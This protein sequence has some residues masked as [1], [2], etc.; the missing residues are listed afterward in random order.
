MPK[1]TRGNDWSAAEVEVTVSAYFD[2]LEAALRGERINKAARKRAVASLLNHRSPDAAE[3]KFRNISAI[4]A[5]EH[6]PYITGFTPLYNYQDLLRDVVLNH[7]WARHSTQAMLE[8]EVLTMPEP[9]SVDDILAQLTAAPVRQKEQ[10]RPARP[11]SVIRAPADYLLMESQ[12]RAL[13][14]AG[15]EFA[16]RFEQARLVAARQER[17]AARVEHVAVSRGDGLGFDVLSFDS[18]GRE[19][20]IE[21]KTTKSGEF[22]PFYVSRNELAVSRR[23]ASQYH[24]YR[25]FKYGASPRLF[26]VSGSLDRTCTLEPTTFIARA[27]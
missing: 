6:V 3:Y 10:R 20:L 9:P 5:E 4:L 15:E 23:E 11:T 8:D 22:M 14:R 12:N 24:L 7:L 2:M 19:R 13:G 1:R 17:L 18:D 26:V 21:V 25:V 16:I 27:N